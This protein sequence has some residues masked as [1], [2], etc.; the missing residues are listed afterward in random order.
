MANELTACISAVVSSREDCLAVQRCR[1]A[2]LPLEIVPRTQLDDTEFHSCVAKI[3]SRAQV[4]LVCM[5]GFLCFW[6]IPAAFAGRVVNIHPA[7]LPRFG[8]Q[9]FYGNRVHQAVLDSG[10]KVSGC[11]VHYADNEYDHGP[12]ILQRKVDVLPDDDAESLGERVHQQELL[13]YPQA[14]QM[15]IDGKAELPEPS[16]QHSR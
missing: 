13:A 9:G 14:I 11:T 6:K 12:T 4:E 2:G 16:L 8:G 7:L 5:A 3:L 1:Q 15:F 10:E